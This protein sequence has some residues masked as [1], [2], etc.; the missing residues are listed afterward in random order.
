MR[1]E[2]LIAQSVF[3]EYSHGW[4]NDVSQRGAKVVMLLGAKTGV[5]YP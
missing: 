2:F 4:E 3:A 5:V 1:C